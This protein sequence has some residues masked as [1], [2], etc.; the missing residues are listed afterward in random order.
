[1]SESNA[2]IMAIELIVK[3][4]EPI[5]LVQSIGSVLHGVIME[6]IDG[7]YAG[8]LHEYTIRPYSQY[9]YFDKTAQAFIWKIAGVTREAVE[10]LVNV[11]YGLPDTIYLT[12][13]AGNLHII[14]RRIVEMTTYR[15]LL[16]RFL[17]SE[18][19]YKGVEFTFTSPTSFKVD[20]QYTIYPETFRMYRYVLKRWNSFSP[21]ETMDSPDL[22]TAIESGTSV[23]HYQ[24][25]LQ[26]FGIERIAIN[27]FKGSYTLQFKQKLIL[28]KVL[29]LL[30]YY[31]QFTGLGIKT[32]LGMGGVSVQLEERA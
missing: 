32:A 10:R 18:S 7:D 24:L 28:R 11:V 23:R 2:E 16:D 31:A 15:E 21:C 1:M 3:A 6:S 12:Q 26:R 14:G 25:H 19:D 5:R 17:G 27:G 8:Q 20:G 13:K 29:A 22:S 4:D 30:S 9:I